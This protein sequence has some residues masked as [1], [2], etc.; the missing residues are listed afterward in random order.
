LALPERD[1][2]PHMFARTTQRNTKSPAKILGALAAL[3]AA[4]I[5]LQ[6]AGWRVMTARA[7]MQMYP[8]IDPNE[9]RPRDLAPFVAHSRSLA[10]ELKKNNLFVPKPPRENPVKEVLGILGS[11]ALI[12]GEWYKAGDHVGDAQVVAVDPTQVKIL[13]DG[14]ETAFAPIA[15]TG[16]GAS[17]PAES[18]PRP[19]RGGPS[20]GTAPSR[21]GPRPPGGAVMSTEDRSGLRERW[22]TMSQEEREKFR[23]E[24]RARV[25]TRSR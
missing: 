23:D 2:H 7:D 10:E 18:R 24:M 22:K 25:R 12:N 17:G 21:V 14:K 20:R 9:T 1:D 13:W 8:A 5:L 3:L 19:E 11:E 6:L 4:L 15:A 16:L